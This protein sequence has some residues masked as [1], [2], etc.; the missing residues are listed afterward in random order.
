[1]YSQL[2]GLCCS[3]V[4]RG[5]EVGGRG[6]LVGQWRRGRKNGVRACRE[7]GH[8]QSRT[9]ALSLA[10]LDM[11]EVSDF[12]FF[13][14]RGG[15]QRGVQGRG[16]GVTSYLSYLKRERGRVPRSQRGAWAPGSGGVC[17][18]WGGKQI[19]FGDE[20][21]TKLTI[22]CVLC[23]R[24]SCIRRLKCVQCGVGVWKCIRS[25]PP[26]PNPNTG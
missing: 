10:C 14:L 2:A 8:G 25:L 3:R 16:R 21:P 22:A 4:L 18:E 20:I 7:D 12:L 19:L 11:V 9:A 15:G 1:M 24:G 5:G 6:W 13:L 23:K 17:G 26:D